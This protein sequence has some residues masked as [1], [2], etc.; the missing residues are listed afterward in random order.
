MRRGEEASS[1]SLRINHSFHRYPD[2]ATIVGRILSA[3]GELEFLVIE[4]ARRV[5]A[6]DRNSFLRAMYRL[7][8]TSARLQAADAFL[9]PVCERFRLGGEYD[10]IKKAVDHCLKIRNQFSHCNWADDPNFRNSGIFFIDL[11]EAFEDCEDH[12][13]HWKPIDLIHLTMQEEFFY[14]KNLF[15]GLT[16]S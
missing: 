5:T 11:E 9:K 16:T 15:T 4:Q 7:R 2:E 10:R 13:L 8:A 14:T 6:N 12:E 3:F 1:V